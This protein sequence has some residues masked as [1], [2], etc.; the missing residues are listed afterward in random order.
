MQI[1]YRFEFDDGRSTTIAVDLD[2][3]SPDLTSP[4]Y[5]EWTQLSRSQCP[6]CPLDAQRVFR[7][8][9]AADLAPTITKF[10]QIV[11]HDEAKVVVKLPSRVVARRAQIQDALSSLVG[12]IMATS[13]CPILSRM[14]GLARSHL[15]FASHEETLLR[16]VG[17]YLIRQLLDQKTGIEPDWTLAGLRAHYADLEL[18]N[19]AFKTR[20]RGAASQDST[21]NAISALGVLSLGIGIS[22]DDAASELG[23]WVY[24]P[25]GSADQDSSR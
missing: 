17:G 3:V 21:L 7:C 20:L 15:P 18:L 8:P 11:S 16:M 12:L 19:R 22:I 5:P 10:A 4:D 23:D 13:A 14:K 24:Q 9:A 1:T 2:R 6:N 25:S